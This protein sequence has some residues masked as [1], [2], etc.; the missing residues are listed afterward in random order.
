MLATHGLDLRQKLLLLL[1]NGPSSWWAT[2]KTIGR[3]RSRFPEV[4]VAACNRTAAKIGADIACAVDRAMV[5]EFLEVGVYHNAALLVSDA[6]F[7]TCVRDRGSVPDGLVDAP[8]AEGGNLFVFAPHLEGTGTGSAAF[9][10]FATMGCD[11]ICITGFDGSI[12]PRTRWQGSEHYRAIPTNPAL[13]DEWC[14]QIKTSGKAA[15]ENDTLL[16]LGVI[17]QASS[18]GIGGLSLSFA[19][20]GLKRMKLCRDFLSALRTMSKQSGRIPCPS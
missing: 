15:M 4:V 13:L 3:L 19:R 18:P 20:M 10:T 5:D 11:S 9:Q 2:A 14:R 17:D 1:G 16:S 12:D 8:R 7:R 6:V